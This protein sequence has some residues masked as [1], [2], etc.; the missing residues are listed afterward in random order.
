MKR[1]ILV[2]IVLTFILCII[3]VNYVDAENECTGDYIYDPSSDSCVLITNLSSSERARLSAA[4][5]TFICSG[6]FNDTG[7]SYF[8]AVHKQIPIYGLRVSLVDSGGNVVKASKRG[9]NYP[10]SINLWPNSSI[11]DSVYA[12]I[13]DYNGYRFRNLAKDS[14]TGDIGYHSYISDDSLNIFDLDN[15][16]NSKTDKIDYQ[17]IINKI[18]NLE[19]IK[20]IYKK[21]N[22][23]KYRSSDLYTLDYVIN[24][25][26]YF[27]VEPIFVLYVHYGDGDYFYM[28]TAYE[29][30][31]AIKKDENEGYIDN[32]AFS[33]GAFL[34]GN[35]DNWGGNWYVMDNF[36]TSLYINDNASG[37]TG[38]TYEEGKCYL[39][40]LISNYKLGW[41]KGLIQLKKYKT[42]PKKAKV[43]VEKYYTDGSCYDKPAYFKVVGTGNA[44]DYTGKGYA[45]W[46]NADG[47]SK[48]QTFEVDTYKSYK[49]LEYSD[50]LYLNQVSSE[51]VKYELNGRDYFLTTGFMT[52]YD[53]TIK[54]YNEK[55]AKTCQEELND[56]ISSCGS[57]KK[58]QNNKSKIIYDLYQLY[59]KYSTKDYNRLF[60]FTMDSSNNL[61]VN[62]VSCGKISCSQNDSLACT[63]T[64]TINSAKPNIDTAE[65]RVCYNSNSVNNSDNL[66]GGYYN[67]DLDA[68]CEVYYTFNNNFPEQTVNS[69]QILWQNKIVDNYKGS[70]AV[71]VSCDGVYEDVSYSEIYNRKIKIN[72][73]SNDLLPEI[74][75]KWK[76]GGT[77]NS[78]NM[79]LNIVGSLTEKNPDQIICDNVA[80]KN[81]CYAHW[82]DTYNF[83]VNFHKKWYSKNNG[84]LIAKDHLSSTT[85]YMYMGTGLPIATTDYTA[86]GLNATFT[87]SIFDN[88]TDLFCPYNVKKKILKDD[89]PTGE[90]DD[91]NDPNEISKEFNFEFRIIN[92]TNPFPGLNGTGRLVGDNWCVDSKIGKVDYKGNKSYVVG[93]VIGNDGIISKNEYQTNFSAFTMKNNPYADV[94]GD[95]E[96][97]YSNNC[98]NSKDDYCILFRY[99]QD[100]NRDQNCKSDPAENYIIKKYITDAKSSDSDATI[101]PMY[102]FTLT[103]N[104]IQNIRQYNKEHAYNDNDLNCDDN[105]RKC[106]S[107]FLTNWINNAIIVTK[108]NGQKAITIKMN[109]QTSSCYNTRKYGNMWCSN[110]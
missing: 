101:Q 102:S 97:T 3:D 36:L 48:K 56:I 54:V 74:S 44:S 37:F 40:N 14:R 98:N 92:I 24:N 18:D 12:I 27:L 69:G 110:D 25:N 13:N 64:G 15:D 6:T 79:D 104:E 78:Q 99:V 23:L 106:K 70:V 72:Q 95:G 38:V 9:I 81:Y 66:I 52:G 50:S 82:T 28:G 87:V 21:M 8:F 63:G 35:N 61:D 84:V 45:N 77:Y 57:S 42:E 11:Y 105:N 91:P 30:A 88:K 93:D 32:H 75:V 41:S 2:A 20:E 33:N 89:C 46:C 68:E 19:V 17:K 109:E 100:S 53:I 22:G 62:N 39:P 1:R 31:N 85:G 58:C 7:W 90:C 103:P 86:N 26:Y 67:A 51:R 83:N 34:C 96:I 65:R 4:C 60:N 71:K 94:N 80:G 10:I 29:I 108:K 43:T 73:F 49:L 47:T 16:F 59:D 107:D 5:N 76:T 55:V